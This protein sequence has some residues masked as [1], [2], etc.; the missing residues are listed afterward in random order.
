[1][2]SCI[3]PW[4]LYDT[5]LFASTKSN[6]TRLYS[7]LSVSSKFLTRWGVTTISIGTTTSDSYTNPNG[8]YHVAFL[9]IVRTAQKTLSNSSVH[10][11]LSV[12]SCFFN[13]L[14]IILF[15]ASAC[16]LVWACFNETW[17]CS[18]FSSSQNHFSS[19]RMNYGPLLLINT[20]VTLYIEMILDLSNLIT[21]NSV[22]DAKAVASIH[23]EK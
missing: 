15:V 16:P 1:M 6:L 5:H 12:S 19:F 23:F 9:S 20:F 3:F 13:P 8:F 11:P 22:V 4:S 14:R 7:L 10:L 17:Q 2:A 18:S 21:S